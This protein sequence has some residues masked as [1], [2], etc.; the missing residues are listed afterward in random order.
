[1]R[2]TIHVVGVLLQMEAKLAAVQAHLDAEH[3]EARE[4]RRNES[5]A[6]AAAVHWK[7][8]AT[9]STTLLQQSREQIVAAKKMV[10]TAAKCL[11][12]I[13]AGRRRNRLKRSCRK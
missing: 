13:L 9:L 3:V 8:Q 12:V 1:M 10:V 11:Q 5:H 6:R 7:E 4:A 2:R